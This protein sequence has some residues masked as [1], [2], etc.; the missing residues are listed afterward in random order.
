MAK[1]NKLE[2]ENRSFCMLEPD[3]IESQAVKDL[4]SKA[5]LY[6]LMRFHQKVHR[7]K[8]KRSQ[9]H[10]RRYDYTNNGELVFTYAEAK[11]LG[12]GE[13]AFYRALRELV[14]DKGFIDIAKPGNWYLRE[15]TKYAISWRWKNYG[16]DQYEHQKIPRRLPRS[17]GFQIGNYKG[18][19]L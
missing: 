16:T 11:E 7:K 6:I 4:S 10:L 1:K 5:A 13:S 17:V 19:P 15:P 12:I 2:F 3:L 14:E 18:K 8:P 9:R